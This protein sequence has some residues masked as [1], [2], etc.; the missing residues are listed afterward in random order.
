[1]GSPAD[2]VISI[3]E[4]DGTTLVANDDDGSHDSRLVFQAPRT[5]EYLLCITDHRGAGGA[6]YLYR[7]EA[8][9]P[10]PRL[11]AFLPRP[12]RLSQDRQA[13]SVPRGNRVMTFLAVRRQGVDGE[14]RLAPQGLPAGVVN[15]HATIPADRFFVPVVIEAAADAPICGALVQ[16]LATGETSESTITGEFQ[17]A[18]EL[19]HA[20]ADRL[21]HAV[22]VDR[23]AVA[24]V[25]A[26]PFLIRL[27]QTTSPLVR[28]GSIEIM[29]RVN[30]SSDFA[31]AVDVTF[32]F[33]PPWVDGP[34]KIT[35]P[36]DKTTG[37]YVARAFPQATP[38]TWQV[39]AEGSP[40]VATG[41]EKM[42][43]DS[44]SIGPTRRGRRDRVIDDI[45]VASQLVELKIAESPVTGIIGRV[46]AEQGTTFE[47]V[48]SIE[49]RGSLPEQLEATLE[50]LPNRVRASPIRIGSNDS[51]AKFVIELDDT[52]PI[53]TFESLVCRL[54]GTTRVRRS[55]TVSDAAGFSRL[56]LEAAW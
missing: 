8:S 17:Q 19:V 22:T 3:V 44:T 34:A 20:S 18:V 40:I 49:R 5:G 9:E 31:G 53:G 1:M 35:I 25:E 43:I 37:V 7:V 21:Y 11:T 42:N 50:G 33:L 16:I 12:D 13:I 27:D 6:N 56:L 55:R 46:A 14:V 24:V 26:A 28:D 29:V 41:R 15:F 4:V 51:I 54:S 39:C 30:R 52:A 32:P 2:T 36:G 48:C 23:L 45:A 10:Q 38:R 47:V